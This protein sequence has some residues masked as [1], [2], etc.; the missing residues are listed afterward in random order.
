MEKNGFECVVYGYEAEPAY[1]S[2]SKI[3]YFIGVLHQRFA[4]GFMK[5]AIFAFG[6]IK[7]DIA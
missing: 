3:A 1:L 7:K 6:K 2:F 5:S 4:P